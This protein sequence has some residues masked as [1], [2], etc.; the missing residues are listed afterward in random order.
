MDLEKQKKAAD[1]L[2]FLYNH[3]AYNAE[4]GGALFDGLWF[5]LAICCKNGRFGD[6]N[7]NIDISVWYEGENKERFKDRFL[8]EYYEDYGED[9]D[10]K[11]LNSMYSIHIPYID[12]YGEPWKEDHAEYW[13]ETTFFV[14]DGDPYSR[15]DY[16]DPSKW[17]AYQ[18][19]E[20][21]SLSFEDMLIEMA[22][23]TKKI[24]GNFSCNSFKTAAEKAYFDKEQKDFDIE[25]SPL[26]SDDHMVVMPLPG[27]QN[28]RWLKWFM[29]TE[30]AKE[31]WGD[32]FE[33]W[34]K[35]V[36]KI[37]DLE[38]E[39]RKNLLRPFVK[40]KEKAE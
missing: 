29:T 40:P 18:A 8:K 38:P 12:Y 35:N 33:K 23:A 4:R 17:M 13:Y 25:T 22:E 39:K 6:P 20:D 31:H 34:Q 5:M 27:L 3:P 24:Y 11:A 1:A 14:F 9:A 32:C 15:T 21:G 19:L 10:L 28:L 36:D 26:F 16:Y 30:Y 7:G 2:E 37:Y